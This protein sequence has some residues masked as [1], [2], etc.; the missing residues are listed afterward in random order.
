MIRR[1]LLEFPLIDLPLI[2][3]TSAKGA[4]DGLV[5]LGMSPED[6]QEYI[7]EIAPDNASGWAILVKSPVRRR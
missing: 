2:L 4:V 7:S 6:A 1:S 5:E 3:A